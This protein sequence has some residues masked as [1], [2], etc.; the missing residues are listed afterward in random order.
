VN[1]ISIISTPVS[2][3]EASGKKY[4]QKT[5]KEMALKAIELQKK[6]Q[7]EVKV[8]KNDEIKIGDMSGV[9]VITSYKSKLFNTEIIV[10]QIVLLSKKNMEF[11][12][13]D[14]NIKDQE[15]I[16]PI[17]EEMVQTYKSLIK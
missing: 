8:L 12:N 16:E 4:N 6:T 14:M 10:R 1:K 11:I 13:I 5:L 2:V 9:D 7:K 3:L 17:F 15:K